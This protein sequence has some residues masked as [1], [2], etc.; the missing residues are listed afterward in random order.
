MKI[1]I[2]IGCILANVLIQTVF[3]LKLGGIPAAMSFGATILI[4]N[5]FALR[6]EY[7]HNKSSKKYVDTTKGLIQGAIWYAAFLLGVFS[8]TAYLLA[9]NNIYDYLR[10][11]SIILAIC[12][13]GAITGHLLVNRK[14]KLMESKKSQKESFQF[15]DK[16]DTINHCEKCGTTI[17]Q[18]VDFPIKDETISLENNQS[19][20]SYKKTKLKIRDKKKIKRICI[21]LFLVTIL[22]VLTFTLFIPGIRYLHAKNLLEK[23]KC[24]LAYAEFEKLNKFADSEDML[25]ECRYIQAIKYRDAGDFDLANQIFALLGDYKDSKMLIHKHSYKLADEVKPTCIQ[26]GTKVYKC[27]NCGDCY[28]N[29]VNKI[30]H[31]YYC[32]SR[33]NSTC[34]SYGSEMYKCIT[35]DDTYTKTLNKT[36]HSYELV[37]TQNATCT[38]DGS[39]LYKCLTC[40][41]TYSE[42]LSKIPHTYVI[43]STVDSTCTTTGVKNNKCTSCGMEY[44]EEIPLKSHNYA[45]ATCLL[46]KTCTVCL[47]TD[48]IALGHTTNK[49]VCSRC[50]FVLFETITFSGTGSKVITNIVLPEGN[51]IISG[52]ATSSNGSGSFYMYLKRANGYNAAYWIETFLSYKKTIEQAEP[53]SGAI[54]GGLLEI[55]VPDNATWTITIEATG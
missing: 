29:T 40:D 23:G 42:V 51:F 20:D 9:N 22:L 11:Q 4:A 35:C 30:S 17:E 18:G 3:R 8:G 49:A 38:S 48:G 5:N 6:Y 46:P 50:D 45:D 54:S 36:S 44:T 24:E 47:A 2:W 15:K 19:K 16:T 27:E 32:L 34:T 37:S 41:D 13:V 39:K 1:L 7:R 43:T 10:V 25:L 31:N 28:T 53:F 55:T 33:E 26:M 21:V 52:I 12:I 14:F